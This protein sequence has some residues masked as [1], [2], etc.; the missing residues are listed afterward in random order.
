MTAHDERG[1]A[2]GPVDEPAGERLRSAAG[3]QE[4]AVADVPP[5]SGPATTPGL[6]VTEDHLADGRAITYFEVSR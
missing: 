3:R 1:P 6:V 5:G 4:C 2:A